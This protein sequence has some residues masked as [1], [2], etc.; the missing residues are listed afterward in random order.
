M[1]KTLVSDDDVKEALGLKDFRNLSKDKIME[2]VSLVPNMDK[3]VAI[4]IIKQFPSFVDFANTAVGQL[5]LLVDESIK[6][7]DNSNSTTLDAYRKI[8]DELSILLHKEHINEEER[9]WVIKEMSMIA[10]K[11]ADKD[12][13]NKAYLDNIIKYGGSLAAGALVLG[14]A[15]LGVKSGNIKIPNIKD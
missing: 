2:F 10:D 9:K 14:A 8:L 5:K 1:S 15:I 12:S 4:E 3:E 7:N 6:A 13:E 11:M